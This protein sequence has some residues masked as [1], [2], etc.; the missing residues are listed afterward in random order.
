MKAAR[1]AIK[2]ELSGFY[3][4]VARDYHQVH[5]IDRTPYSPLKQR[6]VYIEAM[7]ESLR[8]P[9]GARIL[10]VGCGPGEL[11]LSLL[12][13]GYDAVGIDIS[14]GMVDE[15]ARTIRHNGFPDFSGASVGDIE[16]L[17]FDDG[18]FDVVVASGVIEYQKD[19]RDALSEMKRVLRPGGY[20]IL[21]VTN[22]R[23]YVT[24]SENLYK[25]VKKLAI[26]R[27]FLSVL[28]RWI[29]RDGTLTE[30]PNNRTHVPR[31]FDAQLRQLGF[32]KIAHNF[33]RFSPL[34]VP[35]DSLCPAACSAA[36]RRMES[37]TRG[38]LG[39]LGG[40]Y[41][42]MARKESRQPV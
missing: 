8:L 20:L 28:R 4:R 22:R 30:I 18:E 41:I 1:A 27:P 26:M 24:I 34:P 32:Q 35:L 10:D 5:Y 31:R 7:I 42:V 36:A 11:L 23:S 38:P 39:I 21:N 14:A 15:A 37:L 33:F 12:V 17:S 16:K 6:Q 25:G 29:R 2:G 19:D 3:D 40:G 13:K 9:R